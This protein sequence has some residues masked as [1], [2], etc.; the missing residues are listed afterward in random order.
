MDFAIC[1]PFGLCTVQ[2]SFS[3]LGNNYLIIAFTGIEI[4]P[5]GIGIEFFI[6]L[7]EYRFSGQMARLNPDAPAAIPYFGIIVEFNI[8]AFNPIS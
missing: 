2:I 1:K 5:H 6:S 7:G 8:I 4:I 3:L